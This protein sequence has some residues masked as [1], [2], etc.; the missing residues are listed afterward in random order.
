MS[1][2]C[3]AFTYLFVI[4]VVAVE[5]RKGATISEN[6]TVHDSNEY[7]CRVSAMVKMIW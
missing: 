5:N 2:E 6:S 7:R 3:T 1:I 4:D